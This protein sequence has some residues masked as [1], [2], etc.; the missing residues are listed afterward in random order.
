MTTNRA[1]TGAG[2]TAPT[3]DLLARTERPDPTFAAAEVGA[4]P[5]GT[6][7]RLMRLG[8]LAP[9]EPAAVSVCTA[10]G[11]D[12][13][14]PVQWTASAGAER[15]AYLVCPYEGMAVPL[16]PA[17]LRRW[18]VR[19]PAL[20]AVVASAAGASGTVTTRV[21]DR[22]WKLGTV[23][24]GGRVWVAFLAV[25]LTRPDAAAVAEA[26]PELRAAN[27]LVFVPQTVP[28]PT[29]WA[30]RAPVVVPLADLLTL[31]PKGMT[32]DREQLASAVTPA[33][34]PVPKE[35]S[36]TF[37]TPPGATWEQ[38][39]LVVG[40]HHVRVQVGSVAE[41]FGFTEA[42][43]ADRRAKGA[44]DDA[45]ALLGLLARS[46]G[47]LGTDDA[48][49]TK[50]G[51]LKQ[52][53]GTLRTRLRGL[54]GIEADPFHP[55]RKGEPYRTRF[56]ISRDGP[57][58]FPTPPSA[59]WDDLTVTE[60]SDG[61]V[62]SVT[63]ERRDIASEFGDTG[64]RR[65]V[66][67]VGRGE[68]RSTHT[69]SDLGLTDP[70]G[71]PTRAGAAFLDLLRGGGRLTRPQG[72]PELLA[73]GR[74]LAQ[75]FPLDDPPLAFDPARALWVARFEAESLVPPSDRS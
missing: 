52:K 37:P 23:R 40:E 39:T 58:V 14:E 8:L 17:V 33:T 13:V 12:H 60:T 7:A 62:I 29:V 18:A 56:T 28:P 50:S 26:V 34:R 72:A 67:T 47:T 54:L 73:L 63:V 2:T 53:V 6:T 65:R 27:A 51:G 5:D 20:A 70:D 21:P 3:A 25:G 49:R 9:I 31:G 74:A 43:F 42:G 66:G 32:A 10:C 44:P 4:W 35:A 24:V 69:L 64:G 61:V 71:A 30:D 75:F 22:V 45:W 38:V 68:R 48:V 11:F 55:T 19:A 41:R 46:R 36:R 1:T 59:T 57:V 15:R 16:D